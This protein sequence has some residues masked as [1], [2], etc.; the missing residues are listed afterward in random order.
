M[1]WLVC[2]ICSCVGK[3]L[4][5]H[6]PGGQPAGWWETACSCSGKHLIAQRYKGQP[7]GCWELAGTI[8]G[9]QLIVQTFVRAAV[10]AVW[11]SW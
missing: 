10:N 1:L 11:L 9:R 5:M 7:A 2:N 3:R 8:T 4:I 6:G